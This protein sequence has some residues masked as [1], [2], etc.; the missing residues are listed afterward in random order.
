MPLIPMLGKPTRVPARFTATA[1]ALRS[2]NPALNKA[3]A[4]E[5]SKTP[6]NKETWAVNPALQAAKPVGTINNKVA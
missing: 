5:A 4:P 3:P 2:M 6:V 1:E